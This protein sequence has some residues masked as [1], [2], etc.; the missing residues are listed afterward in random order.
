MPDYLR[1]FPVSVK[2]QSVTFHF[3][4]PFGLD[5]PDNA[6]VVVHV[7]VGAV[8]QAVPTAQD[9]L[10]EGGVE[11]ALI[12]HDQL[13][14]IA[15]AHHLQ[16]LVVATFVFSIIRKIEVIDDITPFVVVDRE[17]PLARDLQG[18]RDHPR[19]RT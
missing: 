17:N 3:D 5:F 18:E 9:L 1:I 19:S 4:D 12:G 6:H 7:G 11:V 16:L 2:N 13:G 14:F 15:N 10:L 8:E